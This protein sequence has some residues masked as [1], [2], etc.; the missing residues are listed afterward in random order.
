MQAIFTDFGT[1]RIDNA[2]FILPEKLFEEVANHQ[3]VSES[4]S[5]F[6]LIDYQKS[7]PYTECNIEKYQN[8]LV[9]EFYTK[10]E[11]SYLTLKNSNQFDRVFLY[12][13]SVYTKNDIIP[14]TVYYYSE[15][16]LN[17]LYNQKNNFDQVEMEIGRASCR[18]RV[19]I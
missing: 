19:Y 6:Y 10:Y 15:D 4:T 17:L 2:D 14:Y 1:R 8:D 5:G 7:W 11:Y 3:I 13:H 9:T 18:E 16:N 12:C